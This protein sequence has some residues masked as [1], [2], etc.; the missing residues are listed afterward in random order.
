V[1]VAP[2]PGTDIGGYRLETM[3]GEGGMGT[4]Y[5]ATRAADG[6][7][8]A[9]KIPKAE[10]AQ[11]PSFQQR[12]EREA[13]YAASIEH[14][15]II[16]VF[17]AGAHEGTPYMAMRYVPGADLKEVLSRDAPLDPARTLAVLRQIAGALDAAHAAG[18]VHRDVKPGNVMIASGEGEDPAGQ[19]F[20]TDFGLA[21]NPGADS[22]ALT[23]AGQFVGTTDYVPPEQIMGK[24]LDHR[25][26]I[27]ALG[28]VLFE[29]LAARVPFHGD[30]D[31]QVLYAHL[32]DPP[33]KVTD[34]RSDLPP[35]IDDVVAKAMEKEPEDRFATCCELIEAAERAL[36]AV[37]P[38]PA[39]PGEPEEPHAAELAASGQLV[40][41]VVEGN[42]RGAVIKVHDMLE[43]GRETSGWG[44][45]GG[46]PQ[47][48]RRHAH[49]VRGESGELVIEDLGSTNGTFVNDEQI[50]AARPIGPGDR[51]RLGTT[52]LEVRTVA[53]ASRET[54][55]PAP[56]DQV[57]PDAGPETES[58][59]PQPSTVSK[60]S[61]A[62]ATLT[63]S[64]DIDPPPKEIRV[65]V[66]ESEGEI[67]IIRDDDG[68]RV[69]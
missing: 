56:A 43:M 54:P 19:A 1:A 5:L 31:L 39:A 13:S 25:I 10:L 7:R 2:Q 3:L 67:R 11:E 61:P 35:A 20:V 14:P 34:Y 18:L 28:C 15:A 62:P 16:E 48:S 68:W 57:D 42:A 52:T 44:Q 17:D 21:K 45:L 4:V 64:F 36:G 27:Y 47:L 53:D 60:E 59:E 55:T 6:R 38:P 46:D 12:F 41:E 63:L 23:A 8:A 33:P 69:A 49:I 66:S 22:I 58:T 30:G 51:I 50:A 26:D 40:L 9:V 65:R 29:C 32:Q 24:E 37:A